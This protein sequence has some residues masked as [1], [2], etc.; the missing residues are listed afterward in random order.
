M[1]EEWKKRG[2]NER[3]QEMRT[4]MKER[5]E[6]PVTSLFLFYPEI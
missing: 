5:T 4:E 2:N 6:L 3:K 1:R